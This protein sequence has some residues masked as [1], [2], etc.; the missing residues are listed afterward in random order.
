VKKFDISK[1]QHIIANV[2][3][4]SSQEGGRM[5]ATPEGKY[6]CL[7]SIGGILYDSVLIHRERIAPG[8]KVEGIS[9]IFLTEK[10]IFSELELGMQIDLQDG[11]KIIATAI[12]QKIVYSTPN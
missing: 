7:S 5:T 3:F 2:Q 8:Q 6:H 1:V 9:I 10:N 4:R 12:V 11:N